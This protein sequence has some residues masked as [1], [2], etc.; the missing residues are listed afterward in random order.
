ML[1]CKQAQAGV[2][3]G[4]KWLLSAL[5]VST[6]DFLKR[7]AALVVRRVELGEFAADRCL[8]SGEGLLSCLERLD[9]D[10]TDHVAPARLLEVPILSAQR[11]ERDTNVEQV[12]A[13][14]IVPIQVAGRFD[15]A[16]EEVQCLFSNTLIEDRFGRV[17]PL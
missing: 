17:D 2:Q 6:D 11:L 7:M 1:C 10:V 8:L 4:S 14:V 9:Q 15:A 5:A 3:S 12:A 13:W 16:C